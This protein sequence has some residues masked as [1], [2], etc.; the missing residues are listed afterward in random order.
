M[1]VLVKYVN[2]NMTNVIP[3]NNS[4]TKPRCLLCR[5]ILSDLKAL[6]LTRLNLINV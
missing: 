2:G 5:C 6:V 3:K 4:G 1:F